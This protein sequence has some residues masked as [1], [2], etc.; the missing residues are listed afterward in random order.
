MD[1]NEKSKFEEILNV[2][3]TTYNR[4]PEEN[5][6]KVWWFS[7][8]E[9]KYEM[10]TK[11]VEKYIK[12]NSHFPKP[13]DIINLVRAEINY[14]QPQL[15]H[16]YTPVSK[17]K[18]IENIQR[19]KDLLKGLKKPHPKQWC[20]SILSDP[21]YKYGVGKNIA[22]KVYNELNPRELKEPDP[23]GLYKDEV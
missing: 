3:C 8:K 6:F 2:L 4:K 21:N 15:T 19:I 14:S 10:I 1:I 16:T 13:F 20:I 12:N 17:E 5:L 7:L 9:F 18:A 22:R 11:A 23:N